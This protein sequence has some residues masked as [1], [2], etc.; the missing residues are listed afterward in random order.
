M[1]RICQTYT[2][3][4][5]YVTHCLTVRREVSVAQFDV[6]RHSLCLSG[7]SVHIDTQMLINKSENRSFLLDLT[8]LFALATV[9]FIQILEPNIVNWNEIIF[10]AQ[11]DRIKKYV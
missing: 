11:L 10:C 5:K 7:K 4:A 2:Y 6:L 3:T 1:W 9:L 8:F